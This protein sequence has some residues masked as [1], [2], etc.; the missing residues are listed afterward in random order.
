M[1]WAT[2]NRTVEEVSVHCTMG[3]ISANAFMAVAAQASLIFFTALFRIAH[4]IIF[5]QP[6]CSF[7]PV[8][9]VHLLLITLFLIR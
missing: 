3:R 5:K 1:P 6:T 9:A 4:A 8:I 2:A 7:V